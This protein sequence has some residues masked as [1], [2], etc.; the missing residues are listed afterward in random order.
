[1]EVLG[2]AIVIDETA[3][4]SLIFHD[5]IVFTIVHEFGAVYYL[6][7]SEISFAFSLDNV[8][9]YMEADPSVDAAALP[10]INLGT[11]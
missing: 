8:F 9:G 6:T 2:H 11:R 4:F 10:F 3:I 5:D 7:V 1:M